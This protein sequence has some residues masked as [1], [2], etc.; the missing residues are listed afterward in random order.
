MNIAGTYK[1]YD[2]PKGI[3]Q[4]GII[5]SASIKV[6]GDRNS[7]F[8]TQTGDLN[9]AVVKV[10]FQAA[11]TYVSN[12]NTVDILQIGEN[13]DA[14]FGLTKG[15]FNDVDISQTGDNNYTEFSVKYG[16]SNILSET[17]VGYGGHRTRFDVKGDWGQ[18]SSNNNVSI[19]KKGNS[20]YVSGSITNGSFNNIDVTQFGKNNR[21]GTSWYTGDG[22][23][24]TGSYNNVTLSQKGEANMSTNVVVGGGNTISVAQTSNSH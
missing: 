11:P 14:R 18:V 6:N 10:G 4:D 16:D 13:N 21:V 22:I 5:N 20:N 15:D 23:N 12:S 24:V 9:N 3:D 8:V 2:G 17:V 7:T 19:T 1:Y